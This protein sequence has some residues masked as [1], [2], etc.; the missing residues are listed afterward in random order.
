MNVQIVMCVLS[1]LLRFIYISQ[2][3]GVLLY[4]ALGTGRTILFQRLV[5]NVSIHVE[6]VMEGQQTTVLHAVV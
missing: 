3:E 1:V 6:I 5:R 2:V 4:V